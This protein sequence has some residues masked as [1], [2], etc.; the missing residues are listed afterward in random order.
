MVV[1]QANAL[2]VDAARSDVYAVRVGGTLDRCRTNRP[3]QLVH[4]GMWRPGLGTPTQA[5]C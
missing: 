1:V 5:P 3:V 2:S 4:V